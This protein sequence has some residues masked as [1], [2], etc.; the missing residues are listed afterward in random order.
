MTQLSFSNFSFAYLAFSNFS[1]V[2]SA[3]S[4][5]PRNSSSRL[6]LG[7]LPPSGCQFFDRHGL[8]IQTVGRVVFVVVGG[9]LC[10]RIGLV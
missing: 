3:S 10:V 6:N 7:V 4:F 8:I 1:F 2:N 9:G 5:S